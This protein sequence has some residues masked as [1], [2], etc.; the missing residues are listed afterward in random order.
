MNVHST[1][2]TK[3][4]GRA[5]EQR[6]VAISAAPQVMVSQTRVSGPT[7]LT[8]RLRIALRAYDGRGA[9]GAECA[10]A[11]SEGR[12]DGMGARRRPS[13]G[14]ASTARLAGHAPPRREAVRR[15]PRASA[16]GEQR[17]GLPPT[18][19]VHP[20]YRQP[21]RRPLPT[22]AVALGQ[23]QEA[24]RCLVLRAQRLR[25]RARRR[26]RGWMRQQR[27]GASCPAGSTSSRRGGSTGKPAWRTPRAGGAGQVVRREADGRLR[28]QTH[29]ARQKRRGRRS[30]SP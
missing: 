24:V 6:A 16:D 23:R 7:L 28:V 22:T 19:P 20:R 25:A 5:S 15:R 12:A 4:A 17:A 29:H 11:V 2:T 13:R 8:G 26:A 21:N 27:S 9:L 3:S 1:A 18:T 30:E 14:T 10:L